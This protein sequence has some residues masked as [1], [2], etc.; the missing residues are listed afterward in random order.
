MRPFLILVL[1]LSSSI[2]SAADVAGLWVGYYAYEP[3]AP[4]E[5][6]ECAMVL[7]QLDS[8]VDGLM[9]ERQTFGDELLPGL[10]SEMFGELDGNRLNL[11]K[12]YFHDE[13]D[14]PGVVYHLSLSADG[15]TLTGSWNVSGIQ[16]TAYFRRV[17]AAS[18]RNIPLPR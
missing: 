6:V 12:Y 18:A 3:G 2:A 5:R 16:G 14:A 9:I 13:E 8:D 10:P 1:L 17:T 7:E 11:E 15:N 4:V